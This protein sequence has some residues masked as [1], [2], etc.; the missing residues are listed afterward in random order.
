MGMIIF[1][2]I[3]VIS[4]IVNIIDGDLSNAY[5]AGSI[6][7][8]LFGVHLLH[9]QQERQT[10]AFLTMLM[11]NKEEMKRDR[12]KPMFWEDIPLTYD[13]YVVQYQMC[14]SILFM[15]WEN[16]TTYLS[17][18]S[19]RRYQMNLVSSLIA[20][21]TGWWGIPWGPICTVR[22][23]YRNMRGGIKTPVSDLINM[24]ENPAE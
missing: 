6:S 24:L 20:L 23:L 14:T 18:Q 19:P 7:L 1:G 4:A 5:A 8:I 21:I 10:S 15:T 13:S 22:S 11:E 17:D 12:S 16:A 9:R 3:F 2:A